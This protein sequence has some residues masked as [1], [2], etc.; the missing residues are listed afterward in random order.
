M[1]EA[2]Q[3]AIERLSAIDRAHP[4]EAVEAARAVAAL[5]PEA[6]C[7]VL[8]AP[9]A[10]NVPGGRRTISAAFAVQS[11][12]A[13]SAALVKALDH[14]DWRPV[15]VATDAIGLMAEAMSPVLVASMT[16]DAN[17]WGLLNTITA[18]RRMGVETAGPALKMLAREHAD[19]RVRAASVEALG[20]MGV[21]E[22]RAGI[23]AAL[24][25][26][27]AEVRLKATKAAGWLRL[28]EAVDGILAF[29]READA[30][31]RA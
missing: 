24:S 7:A 14:K 30:P 22:A 11:P 19:E 4:D 17:A 10:L 6:L 29:A 9:E 26:D 18:V 3:S 1:K 2:I 23:A 27:S 20:W 16:P 21:N 25:E 12:A 8:E 31:G 13:V 28:G 5:G 15:Q